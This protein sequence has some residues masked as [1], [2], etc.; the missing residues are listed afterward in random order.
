M[1]R[2]KTDLLAQD[3][4][5]CR[6]AEG[7]RRKSPRMAPEPNSESCRHGEVEGTGARTIL[8]NM[9]GTGN[10][11]FSGDRHEWG[12]LTMGSRDAY[13]LIFRT[14]PGQKL[15]CDMSILCSGAQFM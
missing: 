15:E 9:D 3:D 7:R 4:E 11:M 8:L 14:E 12:R 1:V 5:G 6:F 13:S 10:F 2:H